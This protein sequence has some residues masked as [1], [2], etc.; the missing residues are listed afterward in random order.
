MTATH[1]P[2]MVADRTVGDIMQRDVVTV[3]PQLKVTALSALLLDREISGAPVV[4]E[5]GAVV[6]VVSQSDVVRL[7]SEAALTAQPVAAEP[8][9]GEPAA[10]PADP[11]PVPAFFR[12]ANGA[13]ARATPLAPLLLSPSGLGSR[14]VA[15]IMMPARFSV[16]AD[17]TI[18]GLA[19]YLVNAGVH[20]ALV[21]ERER[22]VG[23]VTTFDVLRAIS[24]DEDV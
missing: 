22:L 5:R 15:E 8:A 14:T 11:E 3:T 24:E 4:D 20:R 16:R 17:T 10:K 1:T 21:M 9:R 19:R 13:G 12:G 6:G 18:A 7:V 23:I 2:E